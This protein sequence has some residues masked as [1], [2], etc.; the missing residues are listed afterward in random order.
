MSALS[1]IETSIANVAAIIAEITAD[2]KPNYVIDGQSVYWGDYLNVL[3]GKLE[4]L[5]RAK[6]LLSGPFQRATRMRSK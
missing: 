1:D 3:T 4:S 6:Q 2:P 5:L